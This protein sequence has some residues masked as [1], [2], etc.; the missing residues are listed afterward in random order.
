M[1]RKEMADYVEILG[2][3]QK[4]HVEIIEPEKD[5]VLNLLKVSEELIVIDMNEENEENNKEQYPKLRTYRD[6][7]K[8]IKGLRGC[9]FNIEQAL[10]KWE[11][12][13]SGAQLI[14]VTP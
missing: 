11:V 12:K 6:K 4:K 3:H 13:M 7:A 1:K 5:I 2:H 14:D 10:N 8:T 9:E